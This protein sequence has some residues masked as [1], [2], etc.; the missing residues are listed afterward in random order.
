MDHADSVSQE[1]DERRPDPEQLAERLPGE[2]P[3]NAVE[4]AGRF[5]FEAS[6]ELRLIGAE[7]TDGTS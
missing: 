1:G 7:R 2:H 5:V 3:K 6:C 4:A